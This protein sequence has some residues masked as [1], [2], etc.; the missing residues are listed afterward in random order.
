MW[1][2]GVAC[3]WF[4]NTALQMWLAK[5]LIPNSQMSVIEHNSGMVY[6]AMAKDWMSGPLEIA[7]AAGAPYRFVDIYGANLP[8]DAAPSVSSMRV[9]LYGVL[10]APT[11]ATR[12]LYNDA[13]ADVIERFDYH[14]SNTSTT[15]VNQ[16]PVDAQ[17]VGVYGDA[18]RVI[19]QSWEYAPQTVLQEPSDLG[20]KLPKIL[21]ATLT[22]A[23]RLQAQA[24]GQTTSA[25]VTQTDVETQELPQIRALA[26]SVRAADKSA[27]TVAVGSA[28]GAIAATGAMGLFKKLMRGRG[29]SLAR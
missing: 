17:W 20:A 9:A 25:A 19:Y 8:P 21:L 2:P 11:D 26:D 16:K 14:D 18:A 27:V 1:L 28:A 15:V 12:L 10:P 4:S 6:C 5:L 29:R 24:R 3:C 13:L 22:F 7:V 23:L